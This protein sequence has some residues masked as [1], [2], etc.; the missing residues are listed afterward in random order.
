MTF[1]VEVIGYKGPH[2]G[3]GRARDFFEAFFHA[4]SRLDEGATRIAI[5]IPTAARSGLLERSR[6]HRVAW[7]RIAEA[8]PELEVW[9]V[10][11]GTRTYRRTAWKDWL[12]PSGD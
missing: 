7:I 2:T 8:F 12:E 6:R 10:D 1:H 11:L 4:V 3:S 5:A 9:L